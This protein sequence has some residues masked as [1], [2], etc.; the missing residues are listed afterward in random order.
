VTSA[1]LILREM[2]SLS[3]AAALEYV[4]STLDVSFEAAQ[5][6]WTEASKPHQSCVILDPDSGMW[7]G[8]ANRPF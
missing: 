6:I 1:V 4:K 2:P 5:K 8:T 7:M 3:K